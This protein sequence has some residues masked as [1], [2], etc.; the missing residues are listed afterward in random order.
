MRCVF[1]K[2]P[3]RGEKSKRLRAGTVCRRK[4]AGYTKA[5]RAELEGQLRLFSRAQ[6][7]EKR[8]NFK[9]PHQAA[10]AKARNLS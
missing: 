10:A 1:C 4:F 8:R 5:K 9:R 3:L 6:G 7:T 2:R